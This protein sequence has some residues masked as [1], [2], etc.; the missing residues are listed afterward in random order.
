MPCGGERLF[1]AAGRASPDE[2]G[3]KRPLGVAAV[4]CLAVLIALSTSVIL[5]LE[6]QSIRQTCLPLGRAGCSAGMLPGSTGLPPGEGQA[7]V[8]VR[9]PAFSR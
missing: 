7:P 8:I 6:R 1:R 4:F 3:A 5:A 2:V 9:W